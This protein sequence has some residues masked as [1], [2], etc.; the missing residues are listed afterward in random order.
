MP[1]QPLYV[2]L[3][4]QSYIKSPGNCT[5]SREQ[6]FLLNQVVT[7]CGIQSPCGKWKEI[8][9]SSFCFHWTEKPGV[10]VCEAELVRQLRAAWPVTFDSPSIWN[11]TPTT[12]AAPTSPHP[13]PPQD[14]WW[15]HPAPSSTQPHHFKVL[16]LL[17]TEL[18]PL[19][20]RPHN[21]SSP[22][23]INHLWV[24]S[25]HHNSHLPRRAPWLPWQHTH[26]HTGSVSINTQPCSRK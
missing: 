13:T 8:P 10:Y 9:W 25:L 3:M 6:M 11:S 23:S 16:Q 21:H 5:G 20:C 1:H 15:C 7:W 14:W 22:S 2:I 18:L 12:P 26:T 4:V 24:R 17:F 19:L